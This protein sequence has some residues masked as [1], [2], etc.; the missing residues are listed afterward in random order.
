MNRLRF[1]Y[2][3]LRRKNFRVMVK[4]DAAVLLD[5]DLFVPALTAFVYTSKDPYAVRMRVRIEGTRLPEWVFSRDVLITGSAEPTG[6]GEVRV[7]PVTWRDRSPVTALDTVLITVG[8]PGE[9]ATVAVPATAVRDFLERTQE[10]VALGSEGHLLR[11]DGV[12]A[13]FMR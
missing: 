1:P 8:A 4:S 11:L 10:G 13:R 12:I 2:K 9:Q 6:V 7:R 5:E 3:Y